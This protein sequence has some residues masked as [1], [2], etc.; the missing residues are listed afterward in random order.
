[1]YGASVLAAMARSLIA[2]KF[3]PRT[4]M[5]NKWL[6]VACA[7]TFVWCFIFRSSVVSKLVFLYNSFVLVRQLNPC[8]ELEGYTFMP[9]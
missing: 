6:R 5:L 9:A 8:V 4:S 2:E 1:M 7:L 3:R